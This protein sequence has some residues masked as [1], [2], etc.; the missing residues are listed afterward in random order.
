MVARAQLPNR[1]RM[2]GRHAASDPG[3]VLLGGGC[4]PVVDWPHR[5]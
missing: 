3:T 5:S 1:E 4:R 2:Q